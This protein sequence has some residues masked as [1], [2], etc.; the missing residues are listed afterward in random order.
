M[1]IAH[2]PRC[3]RWYDRGRRSATPRTRV[4]LCIGCQHRMFHT[5]Q[6]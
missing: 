1:E 5:L 3:A 6:N 2:Y 4:W